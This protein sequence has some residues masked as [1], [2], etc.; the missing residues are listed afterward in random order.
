MRRYDAW[1]RERGAVPYWP[2]IPVLLVALCFCMLLTGGLCGASAQEPDANYEPTLRQYYLRRAGMLT[3]K[4]PYH[5]W[6]LE[7]KA[8]LDDMMY[9]AGYWDIHHIV[10]GETDISEEAAVAM[11]RA[12]ILRGHDIVSA[13]ELDAFAI[14]TDFYLL[15]GST[16]VTE[17]Y[18]W[19]LQYETPATAKERGTF[20]VEIESP[21]GEI[22]LCLW[23]PGEYSGRQ[24]ALQ[25]T[26]K[27][28]SSVPP[29]GASI[30][31]A[32]AV[33]IARQAILRQ[34]GVSDGMTEKI[35]RGFAVTVWLRED[36]NLWQVEFQSSDAE[37]Q[38]EF[39]SYMVYISPK[40][41]DVHGVEH[42]G[43]G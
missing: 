33:R 17:E 7:D 34:Y 9:Q 27:E 43:N 29:G 10:P 6:S 14:Y 40:T 35:L 23:Y 21:S 15:G 2:A 1:S 13:T 26:Q 5:T 30:S 28:F 42:G 38:G 37:I 39:G 25:S 41:G 32:D 18:L 3:E 36:Q 19:V 31:E 12:A 11:G 8:T 22:V 24:E 16:A 20:R 4:G